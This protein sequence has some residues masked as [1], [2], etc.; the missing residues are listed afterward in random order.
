MRL[1]APAKVNLALH[2]VGRREDGYHL[3]DSLV[4]FAGIG[5]WL[6]VSPAEVMRL[7]VDGPRAGGVPDDARNLAWRAAEWVGQPADIFIEKHL[8]H[9]AGIGGGSADAAAVVRALGGPMAGSEALGADVPV[10]LQGQPARMRGIGE[11]LE[12]VPTLPEMWI[13]LVNPGVEVPTGAVF[14]AMERVDNP[15]MHTPE[16]TDYTSFLT[17]LASTR[18]DM[19]PPAKAQQPVIAEVLQHLAATDGCGLARMSGSGA[20]CFGLYATEAGARTAAMSMPSDWWAE[21][22]HVLD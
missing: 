11:V 9:A 6:E 12:A 22:A 21:A 2:V 20:T 17:W 1:L 3:L 13:T 10:C 16:W 8:P 5:D 4:V 14:A 7:R 15:A 18:N 19:E